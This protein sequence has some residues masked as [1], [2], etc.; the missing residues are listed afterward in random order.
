MDGGDESWTGL[1]AA[2]SE[3]EWMAEILLFESPFQKVWPRL[4]L[5]LGKAWKGKAPFAFTFPACPYLP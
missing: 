3:F 1:C 4:Y 2:G 5:V